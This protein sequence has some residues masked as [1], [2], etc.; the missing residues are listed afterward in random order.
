[1]GLAETGTS[2]RGLAEE[3]ERDL[4]EFLAKAAPKLLANDDKLDEQVKRLV[5]QTA[6][7]EIGKKPEVVTVISRLTAD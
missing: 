3:I 2:G 6:T 7:E 4:G 5:R 1:M